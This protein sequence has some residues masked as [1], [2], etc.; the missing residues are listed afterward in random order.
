VLESVNVDASRD[1]AHA[2][3]FVQWVIR[4]Q[5][6]E[7]HD[8]RAYGG[9]IAG[10]AFSVG[11]EIVIL[12]AGIVTKLEH[13]DRH[14]EALARAG[15]PLSVAMRIR[16]NIDVSRGDLFAHPSDAPQVASAF[17]A[18]LCWMAQKPMTPR[19]TWAIKHGTRWAR[20][21]VTGLERKL[22][23][24]TL[25]HHEDVSRFE[26]NDIGAFTFKTSA[27]LAFDPYSVNRN[28]GS[29]ILVDEATNAT[30]GAGMIEGALES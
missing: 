9:Q 24:A 29:F 15:A 16:D 23:V 21:V 26:L 1:Y 2:R 4:P 20:A 11:D 8:Y 6:D 7:F 19:S 14:T 17:R 27:P 13:I 30:V 5:R 3:F 28:T 25:D 18:K 10:G 12:P 22:D